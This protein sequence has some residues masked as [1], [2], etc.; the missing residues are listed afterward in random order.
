MTKPISFTELARHAHE[1]A[2]K[3]KDKR[4]LRIVN[5]TTKEV[6]KEIDVTGEPN[7]QVIKCLMGMMINLH[8]NYYV[9]DATK[10]AAVEIKP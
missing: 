4:T 10:E 6:V 2:Q 9:E 8:E 3:Q 7:V 5:K 1:L